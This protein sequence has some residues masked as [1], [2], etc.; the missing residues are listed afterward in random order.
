MRK[1]IRSTLAGLTV[2]VAAGAP[3]ATSQAPPQLRCG[4]TITADTTLAADLADCPNNGIV[5]GADGVTLDLNGHTVDGDGRPFET[6]GRREA[7]DTGIVSE[8][9]D[10]VTVRGGAVREFDVGVFAGRTERNRVLRIASS[11]NRYFGFVVSASTRT[12]IRHSSGDRN[13]GPDGDGL[14]I[15]G[16]HRLRIVDSAFRHNAQLGIHIVESSRNL[17]ARNRIA[18]NHDMGVLMEADRNQLR[19]N[20]CVKN[21]ACVIVAPGNRNV[22][23]RNRSLRDGQGIAVEKGDRNLVARNLV[24]RPRFNGIDLGLEDPPIGGLRNVARGN[25]VRHSGRDGFSV[26]RHSH[27][28]ALRGNVAVGSGDDGFDVRS[29]TATLARNVARGSHDLDVEGRD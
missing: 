23:A 26:S 10:D 28:C 22:I 17:I 2:L 27:R 18:R 3:P 7:C 19:G 8:G 21:G 15:F 24:V 9:H 16:S 5:I 25:V 12:V 4:D 1:P 13:P 14:G 6:C 20:R 29:R 11:A